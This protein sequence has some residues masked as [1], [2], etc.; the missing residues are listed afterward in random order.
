MIPVAAR[1]PGGT[2]ACL[3]SGPSLTAEDCATVRGSV[4]GVIAINDAVRLAPWADVLYSSDRAWWMRHGY[5][6]FAGQRYG[7]GSRIGQANPFPDALG[8]AVLTNTGVEGLELAGHGLR[9]GKHSGYAAI[10]LA[11]HLG[12]SRI[13]LLGYNCCAVQGRGHFD[14]RQVNP[15]L[16]Y[17]AKQYR[18][19]VAPLHARGVTV[20]NCTTPTAITA[21]PCVPLATALQTVAA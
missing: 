20:L 5:P 18:A 14:D 21:F 3:A 17:F 9:H 15:N 7:I 6:A 2:I 10:N 1:W 12:A 8:I 4:A 13:L 16:A 19:L 11:V